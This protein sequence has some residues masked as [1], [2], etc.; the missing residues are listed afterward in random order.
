M[1]WQGERLVLAWPLVIRRARGVRIARHIGCGND[2]EY[3]GPLV[4]ADVDTAAVLAATLPMLRGVIDALWVFNLAGDKPVLAILAG[5]GLF[6][7]RQTFL[8]PI[9]R[10]GQYADVAAWR[11]SQSKSFRAVLGNDRRRL[12][13]QGKLESITIAPAQALD[14]CQWFFAMK[15]QWLDARGIQSS[16]LRRAECQAFFVDALQDQ[17]RSG[18]FATALTLDGAYIAGSLCFDG[19]PIEFFST[20]FDPDYSRFGP[21]SLAYE[22]LVAIGAASGR[23]L[24][25]RISRDTYKLR[26]TSVGDRGSTLLIALGVRALP[27]TSAFA[28]RQSWTRLRRWLGARK[29]RWQGDRSKSWWS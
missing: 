21:G 19:D 4:A 5:S 7:A 2:E 6:S 27:M 29:R 14:Y 20:A 16:W 1:V 12:A 8:S 24:D 15:C 11:K 28:L 13:K 25:L 23:D 26:W 22:D 17:T 9:V 18:V 3:A 10:C